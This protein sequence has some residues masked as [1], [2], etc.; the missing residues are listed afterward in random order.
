MKTTTNKKFCILTAHDVYERLLERGYPWLNGF[1]ILELDNFTEVNDLAD[2]LVLRGYGGI[3]VIGAGTVT[4]WAKGIGSEKNIEVIS[5]PST[6]STNA[7]F[8]YKAI[9]Y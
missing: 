3:V 7:M 8:T 1:D 9:F 4:D 6:F 5:V 2:E